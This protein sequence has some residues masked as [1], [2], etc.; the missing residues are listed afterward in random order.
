MATSHLT[1]GALASR[2]HIQT[3][4]LQSWRWRGKGPHY[5]KIGGRILYRLVDVEHFENS[6]LRRSTTPT[7]LLDH[8]N[9]MGSL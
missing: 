3:A 4:T 9:S 2:W 1:P 7:D 8:Y 6:R 5:V